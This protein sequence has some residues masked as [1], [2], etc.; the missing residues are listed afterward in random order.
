MIDP[1]APC[2]CCADVW[3]YIADHIDP[4]ATLTEHWPKYHGPEEIS[5]LYEELTAWRVALPEPRTGWIT[6]EHL[7]RYIR[8]DY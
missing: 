8:G 5:A 6:V 7:E 1:T 4:D 3:S 2:T